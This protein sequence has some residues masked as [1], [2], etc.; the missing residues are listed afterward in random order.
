VSCQFGNRSITAEE[1]GALIQD[2]DW[3]LK[4]LI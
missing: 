2:P 1:Y 4:P 3:E